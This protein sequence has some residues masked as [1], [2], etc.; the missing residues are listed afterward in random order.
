MQ[1]GNRSLS[2]GSIF[3]FLASCFYLFSAMAV[4]AQ[5][6]LNVHGPGGPYPAMK[7]TAETFSKMKSLKMEINAGP[8]NKWI[9]KAKADAHLI[10]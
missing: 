1:I 4:F 10:W 7:E 5:D 8:T 9:E 2:V 6:T 3:V